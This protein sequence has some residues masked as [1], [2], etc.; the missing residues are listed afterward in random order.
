MK[1]IGSLSQC[2]RLVLLGAVVFLVTIGASVEQLAFP[3]KAHAQGCCHC[4]L[5]NTNQ[6]CIN[7]GC[8]QYLGTASCR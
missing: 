3:Q 6:T 4:V 7:V 2:N 8:F 5:C 1:W